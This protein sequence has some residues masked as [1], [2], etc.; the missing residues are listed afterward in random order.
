MEIQ[1][2]KIKNVIILDLIGRIDIDSALFIEIIGQCLRDGYTDILCNFENIQ[3][4]DYVGVSAI[5]IANH[6]VSSHHGKIKFINV[7]EQ[8][9]RLFNITG[10]DQT[11][12]IYSCESEALENF[13]KDKITEKINKMKWRR[14]FKRL[15]LD[16]SIE[17]KPR[18]SSGSVTQKGE[19][20]NLSAVGAYIYGCSQFKLG[21]DLVIKIKLPHPFKEDL[22]LN[23]RVVWLPEKNL[24]HPIYPG[25]G[26]EF[27]PITSQNQQKIIDYIER[28]LSHLPQDN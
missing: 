17:I 12:E 5:A 20:L 1:A 8:A 28:N 9:R 14:R 18:Y 27:H 21:D 22:T 10:L 16:L 7:S 3:S 6:E 11:L 25:I 19:I 4:I 2:R 23:A 13:K 24:Q 15:H 26:V